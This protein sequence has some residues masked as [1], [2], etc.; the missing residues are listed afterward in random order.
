ML[1]RMTNETGVTARQLRALAVPSTHVRRTTVPI[2]P[3]SGA[4]MPS[5][6]LHG[7]LHA[8]TVHTEK[9]AHIHIRT[10]KNNVLIDLGMSY[11]LVTVRLP[12]PLHLHLTDTPTSWPLL[13]S[14]F[15]ELL[16]LICI[17]QI[18]FGVESLPW[19]LVN[20]PGIIPVRKID[21][22]SPSSY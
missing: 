15:N 11:V 4:P 20:L 18:L 17:S 9:Q 19:S 5:S 12:P 16:S 13:L 2:T 6:A 1:E 10:F 21:S 3:V 7:H 14:D 8:F 22:C